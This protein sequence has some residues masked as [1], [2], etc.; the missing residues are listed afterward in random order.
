MCVLWNTQYLHSILTEAHWMY[1]EIS[2][3][4]SQIHKFSPWIGGPGLTEQVRQGVCCIFIIERKGVRTS[5]PMEIY[6]NCYFPGGSKPQSLWIPACTILCQLS[7][8][9]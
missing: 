6:S 9:Y 7:T 3:L 1:Y 4:R 2:I 8:F 5:I